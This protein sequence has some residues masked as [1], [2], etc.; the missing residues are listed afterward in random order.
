[1]PI[2]QGRLEVFLLSGKWK[3]KRS[4][5][6]GKAHILEVDKKARKKIS[7]F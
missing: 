3:T 6:S 7:V 1:M 5:D 4:T 2:E